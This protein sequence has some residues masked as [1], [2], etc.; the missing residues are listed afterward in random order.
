MPD[1]FIPIAEASGQMNEVG[2]AILKYI[3]SNHSRWSASE[4]NKHN[5]MINIS[6]HQL[7]N[8]GFDDQFISLAAVHLVPLDRILIEVT[9]SVFLNNA[10][11]AISVMTSL[12]KRG[13]KFVLD[14]FGTGYSSL[15][16]L[17]K[18]PVEYLKIDKS[19]I[20]SMTSNQDNL[21]IV[22]NILALGKSLQL[23]VIAEGVETQEQFDRLLL[24]GCDFFQGWYLGCPS[25]DL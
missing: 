4:V 24:Q 11:A 10:E 12:H 13:V 18:L 23:E 1:D 21:A 16:Y 19:F 17:Q 14:D 9:E 3:F 8:A 6:A 2:Y 15:A 5:L 25:K 20:G 7:M 22:N